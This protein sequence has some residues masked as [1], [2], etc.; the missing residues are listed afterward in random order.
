MKRIYAFGFALFLS[1]MAGDF[2][3]AQDWDVQSDR[4]QE[5]VRRYQQL[6]ERTP[7]EGFAFQKLLDYVGK[8]KGLDNLISQYEKKVEDNPDKVNFRLILGH[9]FKA[10]SEYTSALEQY[11][12]A[13]ELSPDSSLAWMSRGTAH[14]MLQHEDDASVDFEKA[15]EL[16]T[17]RTKRQEILRKLSDLAFHR[18]DW[19]K[20]QQYYD[21]LV[22]MEPRNE[23]LRMEYA[24]ILVRYKRYDKALEQYEEL[25]KLAGRDAKTKATTMRDMGELYEMMG[26]DN[27]ALE[28]YR[29]AMRLVSSSNWLHKELRLRIVGVYRKTNRLSELVEEYENQWRNPNYDQSMELAELYEELGMEEEALGMFRR[30]SRLNSRSADARLK[31]IRIL[32]RR[33]QEAEVIKAYKDLIRVSRGQSRYEFDLVRV[34][35]RSARRDEATSL[36]KSI[37]RRYSRDLD[38]HMN[39]ADAYMRF[40]MR[41]EAL[42]IYQKLVKL[43]PKNDAFILGLGEFY[44]QSGELDKAVETW[45]KLLNSNLTAA[46]AHAK[47][48]QVLAEHGMVERGLTHYEKAV[49]ISPEDLGVRRGLA[50]AYEHARQWQKSIDTWTYVLDNADHA[51]TSNEARSRIINIYRRTNRLRGKMREFQQAF[52]SRPR[53]IQA[54]FFL[55]ES[56]IRLMA[57]SDAETIYEELAAIAKRGDAGE[58]S[59]EVEIDAL[60]SLDKLYQQTGELEKAIATLQRLA[61]LMPA[62][63]KDYYHRIAEVS[64]RLY[65]DDQAVHYATLAVQLNPD[66][67]MAQARLGDVYMKMG[68]KE[69]AAVQYRQAVDLDPRAY[70]IQMKLATILIELGQLPEA[71]KYLRDLVQKA[72]DENLILDAARRAVSLAEADDR[73]EEVEAEFYPLVYRSPP[74]QVYRRVMVEVYDRLTLPLVTQDQFGVASNKA[75]ATRK[76]K[77]I[78]TRALPVLVDSLQASDLGV[79]A[80]AIRLL[81]DLRQKNAAVALANLVDNPAENLRVE[82]AISVAHLGEPRA[83]QP[84]IRLV[85]DTDPNL[86]ELGIWALGGVGGEKAVSTLVDVLKGGQSWREQTLAA[87]GLGRIGGDKAVRELASF[88]ETLGERRFGEYMGVAVV[89]GLSRSGNPLA[90]DALKKSLEEGNSETSTVAAWGLS[91]VANEAAVAALFEQ[92]WGDDM[93]TRRRAAVALGQWGSVDQNSEERLEEMRSETRLIQ[94]RERKIDVEGLLRHLRVE[95]ELIKRGDPS[96][97][98]GEHADTIAQVAVDVVRAGR[99][100]EVVADLVDSSGR[101]RLGQ[102]IPSVPEGDLD[103]WKS[104]ARASLRELQGLETLN[105]SERLAVL[106][107]I[108]GLGDKENLGFVTSSLKHENSAVRTQA[109]FALSKVGGREHVDELAKLMS[110]S[111]WEVRVQTAKSMG[112]LAGPGGN[113]AAERALLNGLK[114]KFSSVREASVWGL[115]ELKSTSSVGALRELLLSEPIAMKVAC[116]E[117]LKKIASSEAMELVARHRQHPDYRVRAAAN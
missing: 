30:A 89:W 65:Q 77:E 101:P 15:L 107:L 48:G 49:E 70:E 56:H 45:T 93:T 85:S 24:Q 73:L 76:I 39:L 42:R 78:G 82:A 116:I 6:L 95:A 96:K 103:L 37:E 110:D 10:K 59:Q 41:D 21:Q 61:E 47:L 81:A 7:T 3:H 111:S 5:I 18:R 98:L 109:V 58:K 79:R 27:D 83:V 112:I 4:T 50:L 43:E 14:L 86:R 28:T 29:S 66:D 34:Y 13:V 55:A 102:V 115:G 31:V 72:E 51:L 35:M 92:L 106:Q 44:Y 97:L 25:V 32:E 114:D 91:R 94:V 11:D 23:Y 52:E 90:V 33:G 38:V 105:D 17:D 20:A 75:E 63:S 99:G 100:H 87:L 108:H 1:V 36:L 71:E 113:P 9:L 68:N 19:E 12:K 117:A 84:L 62:R 64:L 2:A 67:A 60:V 80:A 40:E 74:K 22:Q 57:Y 8:G 53:D 54:G 69:S 104:I 16:E 46:E 88:Y 26:R